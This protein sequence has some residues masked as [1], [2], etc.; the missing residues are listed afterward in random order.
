MKK[1]MLGVVALVAIGAAPALAA[2]L[3]PA[4]VYGKAPA[5]VAPVYSWTG[6]YLGAN[7]GYAWNTDRNS[8]RDANVTADPINGLGPSTIPTPS[9]SNGN[10]WLGGGEV[11]CNWQVDP[12]AVLGIEADIDALHASGS[13]STS[14]SNATL[15]IGPGQIVGPFLSPS[16]ANE[17]F[18]VSW[19][20]TVRARAGLPVLENRGLIFV[21]GGL[22]FGRVTSSG[23]VNTFFDPPI[24]T[25]Y[26]NWIGANSSIATGFVIGTGFEYSLGNHWTAKAEYLY[27]DIGS[28][29]HSLNLNTNNCC[30]AP[31]IP[32]YS[33]LGSTA[34]SVRGNIVRV[35]LNYLFNI[36]GR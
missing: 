25:P 31:A 9:R 24:A 28:V 7:A 34:S 3:P 21:T 14:I 18:S 11:G 12:R 29:S 6:C 4:P 26:V 13:A 17:Q 19:L 36:P 10:S 20:S 15:A 33:T 8:Y 2:D 23:S 30:L 5:A 22:A 35:G 16:T 1:V 32:P 27:Y